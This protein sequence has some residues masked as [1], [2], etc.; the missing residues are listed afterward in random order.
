M[1]TQRR[2]SIVPSREQAIISNYCQLQQMCGAVVWRA[3]KQN[4][5][6]TNYHTTRSCPVPAVLFSVSSPYSR[7]RCCLLKPPLHPRGVATR[8]VRGAYL[9]PELQQKHK[10]STSTQLAVKV[11]LLLLC[12]TAKWKSVASVEIIFHQRLF[13]TPTN[14]RTSR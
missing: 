8:V 12:L 7:R 5:A 11:L 14:T 3:S 1:V 9:R 10:K 4:E 6:D 2:F 13:N